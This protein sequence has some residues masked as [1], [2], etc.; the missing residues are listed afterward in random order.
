MSYDVLKI[1]QEYESSRLETQRAIE[2]RDM[3][4]HSARPRGQA[5]R[6]RSSSRP[7]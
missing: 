4:K 2:N 1:K 5:R 7:T 3:L 6:R